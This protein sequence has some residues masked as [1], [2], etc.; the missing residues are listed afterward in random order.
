[1]TE[2]IVV[3]SRKEKP[4]MH[5]FQTRK[6]WS[7]FLYKF[8]FFLGASNFL[9]SAF[10]HNTAEDLVPTSGKNR[11]VDRYAPFPVQLLRME[12]L[13][14]ATMLQFLNFH[15]P[16]SSD[17]EGFSF[18][19]RTTILSAISIWNVWPM[20]YFFAVATFKP[21]SANIHLFQSYSSQVPLNQSWPMI[22][23]FY[24]ELN[25]FCE[26]TWFFSF[27]AQQGVF[28]GYKQV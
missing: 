16:L 15:H 6:V 17:I 12:N 5:F 25:E 9:K 7:K 1:M 4:S 23:T 24:S 13:S 19:D 10:E 14:K 8:K 26:K 20:L 2:R 3:R 22:S 21:F 11:Y 27:Q 28:W 18:L